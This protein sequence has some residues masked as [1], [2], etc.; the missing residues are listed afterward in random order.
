MGKIG[1]KEK[2]GRVKGDEENKI[3]G[4]K[5]MKE[6]GKR[7][8][9]EEGGWK[10]NNIKKEIERRMSCDR[11]RRKRY[12]EELAMTEIEPA[13]GLLKSRVK[14]DGEKVALSME[15]NLGPLTL[16]R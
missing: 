14:K 13:P 16:K 12:K 4:G 3:I 7:R 1:G 2:E 9:K 5:R 10:R 15:L 11:D 8:G 6:E